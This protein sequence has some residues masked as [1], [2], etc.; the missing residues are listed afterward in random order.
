MVTVQ[1]VVIFGIKKIT[2]FLVSFLLK[3]MLMVK[4]KLEGPGTLLV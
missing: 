1:Q 3:R 4:G 2:I